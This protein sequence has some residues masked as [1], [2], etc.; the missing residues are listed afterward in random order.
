[1]NI[2]QFKEFVIHVAHRELLGRL[3]ASAATLKPEV[4][5]VNLFELPLA[6]FPDSPLPGLED[7]RI[8]MHC[9]RDQ[10]IALGKIPQSMILG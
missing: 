2:E 3:N 6:E 10:I 9:V 8:A 1:M 7:C 5:E 4:S